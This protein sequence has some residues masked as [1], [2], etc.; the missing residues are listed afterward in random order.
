MADDGLYSLAERVGKALS[1][2]GLLLATAESCTG[3]GVGAAITAVPGSSQW[4]ERGFITYS[5]EAKHDML[6]V[7]A[8]TLAQHGAVSEAVVREMAR[9]A[10][11]MSR[12][13]IALA[14][15]GIAGPGGGS[16][17]KPV[18]TVCFAW[19]WQGGTEH[20]ETLWLAG[21]RAVVRR[22]AVEIALQGLLRLLGETTL[23][24]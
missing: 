15:S 6:G 24:A 22:Q 5:N 2:R 8:D 21:D 14:V 7:S 23:S 4:Y 19:T 18:G 20:R 17:D 3:G 16:A 1:A 12:A 11:R 10:L 9:G 13:Q